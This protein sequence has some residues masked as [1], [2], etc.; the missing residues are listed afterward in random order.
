MTD[1]AP[2]PGRGLKLALAVSVALNLLVAGVVA[3]AFLRGGPLH[4]LGFGPFA[5]ALTEA[6][7][8]ALKREFR[9]RMP[10]LREMRRG[11]RVA[12]AGV[13]A[14][15]R[16]EPFDPAAL[17]AAMEAAAARMGD[18]LRIGQDLLVGHLAAMSPADRAA[19]A[20]RMQAATARGGRKD[21]PDPP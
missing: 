8:A 11:Q 3:G 13:L 16:A 17:A 15:L 18:R 4:D 20:D 21:R 10:D 1:P 19:F 2:R 14:A 9:A 7:H 6:D 5:A 12:M